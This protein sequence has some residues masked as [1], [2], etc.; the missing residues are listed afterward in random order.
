M[1]PWVEKI[2]WG[3]AWQPTPVLFPGESP[4]QRSLAGYSPW[5]HRESDT[6]EQLSTAHPSQDI[7]FG[8]DGRDPM[9]SGRKISSF[10]LPAWPLKK[11]ARPLGKIRER[12]K[13]KSS[14]SSD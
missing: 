8:G 3:K 10:N 6:T 13:L 5:G 12:H 14:S 9:L 1:D 7:T 11:L 4:G 2:P